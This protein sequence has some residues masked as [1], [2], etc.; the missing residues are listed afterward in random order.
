MQFGSRRRGERLAHMEVVYDEPEEK[1]WTPAHALFNIRE[2]T[3][4]KA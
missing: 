3:G 4:R 1:N 2:R